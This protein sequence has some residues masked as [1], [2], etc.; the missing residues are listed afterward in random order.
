MSE[1]LWIVLESGGLKNFIMNL[2]ELE[3]FSVI[4]GSRDDNGVLSILSFSICASELL[5]GILV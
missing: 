4:V 2:D 5:N 3:V 1:T